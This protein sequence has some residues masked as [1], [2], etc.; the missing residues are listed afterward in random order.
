M[1][2]RRNILHLDLDAFFYAV[3]EQSDPSLKGKPCAV[4]GRPEDRGVVASCSYA[5]RKFGIYSP[6][7]MATASPCKNVPYAV[8]ASIAWPMVWP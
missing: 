2:A 5:A 8:D 6:M 4:G 3:E 1:D 7:P